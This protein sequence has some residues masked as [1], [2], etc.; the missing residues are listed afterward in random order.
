MLSP[1]FPAIRW[2]AV[3]IVLALGAVACEGRS[4]AVE[5]LK[6]GDAALAAGKYAL[7]LAAFQHAREV[8]PNDAKVQLALMRSRLHLLAEDPSRL[9]PTDAADAEYEATL[10]LD[11]DHAHAPV[12]LVA[13]GHLDARAGRREAAKQHYEEA[14]KLDATSAL[15]QTALG[16]WWASAGTK[17]GNAQARAAFDA[18][19]RVRPDA[20][21]ALVGLGRVKL[22]EGDASGAVDKL[23]AALRIADD[24]DVR[25]LL[26]EAKANLE[27][28]EEAAEHLRRAAALDPR[29]PQVLLA[30]GK[31]LLAAGRGAEAE[32]ALRAAGA[33]RQDVD[34]DLAL[35]FALEQQQRHVDGLDVFRRILERRASF[36]PALLGAGVASEALGKRDDAAEFYRRAIA[37]PFEPSHRDIVLAAQ[38]DA[39][40]RL[41]ALGSAPPAGPG[42][43]GV[44]A[45][46]A[47]VAPAK[48]A[49]P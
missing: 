11:T 35:G 20:R 46:P 22:A 32:E 2:A 30:L 38:K 48:F 17:D 44:S 47:P 27:K 24:L 25:L 33:L 15:A 3:P 23:E 14:L 5:H 21:R 16:V 39:K 18:A 8:A 42:S 31:S 10:L 36:A 45:S 37:A 19:L 43:P 49:R 40:A 13:L 28:P 26:G 41:A 6:R 4:P 9:V 29:N 7:A 1:R 12:Y 34:A